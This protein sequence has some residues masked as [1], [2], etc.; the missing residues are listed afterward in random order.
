MR[1]LQ[2]LISALRARLGGSKKWSPADVAA[3]EQRN[4]ARL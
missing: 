2:S 3:L 4:R 1:W